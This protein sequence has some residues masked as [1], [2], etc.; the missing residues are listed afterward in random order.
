[1]SRMPSVSQKYPNLYPIDIHV[2]YLKFSIIDLPL[3]KITDSDRCNYGN[4]KT[5]T[6]RHVFIEC[7]RSALFWHDVEKWLRNSTGKYINITDTHQR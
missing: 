5:E 2:P 1:M 6:L 7:L 4:T 3:M